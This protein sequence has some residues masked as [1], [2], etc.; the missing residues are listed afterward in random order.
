MKYLRII[1]QPPNSY[2]NVRFKKY[3]TPC[4]S[5]RRWAG[6]PLLAAPAGRPW[7]ET[8]QAPD[9]DAVNSLLL[10]PGARG[11]TAAWPVECTPRGNYSGP[12]RVRRTIQGRFRTGWNTLSVTMWPLCYVPVPARH[13]HTFPA[14]FFFSYQEVYSLHVR[15]TFRTMPASYFIGWSLNGDQKNSKRDP[16][17][18]HG[19]YLPV[20]ERFLKCKMWELGNCF[21][22]SSQV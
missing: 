9:C 14:S 11:R 8:M 17:E 3:S 10:G 21:G 1:D 20:S 19:S 18:C 7:D 13:V 2:I 22:F 16:L 12:G 6:V 4:R 15:P 5:G